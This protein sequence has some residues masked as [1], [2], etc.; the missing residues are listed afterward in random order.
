[1]EFSIS[2]L[3]AKCMHLRCFYSYVYDHIQLPGCQGFL[4]PN[5]LF[6]F[7]LVYFIYIGILV[8]C[9]WFAEEEIFIVLG[10]LIGYKLYRLYSQILVLTLEYFISPN[11]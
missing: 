8:L 11:V 6:C 1:M 2:K 4:F 10:L 5:Y 3:E 7:R 9:M